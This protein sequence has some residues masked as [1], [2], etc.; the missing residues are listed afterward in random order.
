MKLTQGTDF[1]LN[2][3]LVALA[4]G[5]GSFT[6]FAYRI[7]NPTLVYFDETH[8]VPA[9][10]ALIARSGPVN[11][12]HPI[13]AKMMIAAGI[14]LFGDNSI[15]WRLPSAFFAS[16][17][18][19]ALFWIARMMFG[20][21]RPA[22]FAALLAVFNQ[23]LFVQAR[24]AMLE[25]PMTACILLAAGCLMRA[26][27]ERVGGRKW[28]YAG[29][30]ALGLAVG[31]KWLAIPYAALFFGVAGWAKLRAEKYDIGTVIDRVIPDLSKLVLVTL[32]VYFATFWPTFFYT[33]KPMTIGHLIGFQLEMLHSQQGHL[34]PHPYQSDWWQWPLMLRPIWYL[35]TRTA[36]SYEGVLLVGNPGL[37]NANYFMSW[38]S[39]SGAGFGIP[40]RQ[41]F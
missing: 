40:K 7:G 4:L 17:S 8:Y 1:K 20:A 24:I 9:A 6:L 3:L 23:T 27:S 34:A 25:M 41:F 36:S 14:E 39:L 12:E 2:V 33:T 29:A 5:V 16:V 22:I 30:V 32:I 21:D 37:F 26:E 35:F 28:E 10:R 18:V 13:F 38:I 31:S 15:G 11:I 19:V